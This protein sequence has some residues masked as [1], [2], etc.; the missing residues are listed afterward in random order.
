MC[1]CTAFRLSRIQEQFSLTKIMSI[2]SKLLFFDVLMPIASGPF[3]YALGEDM[4]D[5]PAPVPGNRVLVPFKNTKKSGVLL[6][7]ASDVSSEIRK[8]MRNI[9]KVEDDGDIPFLPKSL[10]EL[11][12]WTARYYMSSPGAVLKYA[13]PTGVWKGVKRRAVNTT[14]LQTDPL[15]SSDIRPRLAPQQ[16][17]VLSGI[18]SDDKG[19][20]LLRG[21][22]GSGKTEVYIRAIESLSEGMGAIVLVPEIALTSQ[23]IA[24]FRARFGKHLDV[25]HSALSEGERVSAWKRARTGASKVVLAV[26]SGIFLP[27]ERLGIIIVDEEHSATYKQSDGLKYSARDLAVVRGALQSAKVVLGS[28]TPSIESSYN[29]VQGKYRLLTMPE[30]IKKRPMPLVGLIDMKNAARASMS[31]SVELAKAVEQVV[32]KNEREKGQEKGQILMLLNRRGYSP[33]V[34]CEDCGHVSKCDSCNVSLTWHKRDRTLRCHHCGGVRNPLDFCPKC[35][36]VKISYIGQGTQRAEEELTGLF[37]DINSVRM[38][39]D[40]TREKFSHE[41][42]IRSMETSENQMILGT[43]MVAKGHDLPGVVLAAVISGDV[44]LGLP[45]FRSA[46]KGFQLFTQLAGRAG[47]GE[48]EGRVFIQTFDPEHYVFRYVCKHDYEGFFNHEIKL[49]QELGYPP[50]SRLARVVLHG[51]V[52]DRFDSAM[53]KV[54][55]VCRGF[56]M[57]GVSLLGP[58]PCPL[59]RLRGRYRWHLL[60][61]S[62]SSQQLHQ[63][64]EMFLVKTQ[65]IGAIKIDVDIDPSNMM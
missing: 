63:A 43:Q 15:R 19:V 56:R 38:D 35:G 36:G 50:F 21:V 24:R 55:H 53:A 27:F 30:R 41:R 25:F 1:V 39:H 6:G 62:R 23:M 12:N 13:V 2:K 26:R 7:P 48:Q 33:M 40:S 44:L 52:K 32:E 45:D 57:H 54:T 22:T 47:R 4:E 64:V 34:L 51:R 8:R 37:P 18:N 29:A 11:I 65:N 3:T 9:I 46:E 31:I 17:E 20:Y 10:L 60:L 49:R 14:S 42:I 59:E 16:A 28:A 61:K 58:A 5:M